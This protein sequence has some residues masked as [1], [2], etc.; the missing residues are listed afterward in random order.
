ML[1][2][3][4]TTTPADSYSSVQFCTVLYRRLAARSAQIERDSRLWKTPQG[5]GGYALLP[6]RTVLYSSVQGFSQTLRNR[7]QGRRELIG[8]QSTT[9]AIPYSSVHRGE[10]RREEKRK[11]RATPTGLFWRLS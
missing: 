10:E 5:V 2:A 9:Y 7:D 8:H 4:M 3:A 11:T 6:I 1:N